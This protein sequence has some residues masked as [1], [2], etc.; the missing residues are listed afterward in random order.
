V[1]AVDLA[2]LVEQRYDLGDL[3]VEQPVQR[4]ATGT[5]IGQ[6]VGGAAAQPPVG[7]HRAKLQHLAGR[8]ELPAGLDR[9]LEQVQQASLGGRLDPGWGPAR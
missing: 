5:M 4:A 9:L 1:G 6:F 3:P 2:P 7:P 8:A